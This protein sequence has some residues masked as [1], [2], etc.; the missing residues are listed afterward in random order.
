MYELALRFPDQ[1]P[2][3]AY[4]FEAG[5]LWHRLACETENIEQEIHAS[6]RQVCALM[7]EARG[8]NVEFEE[9]VDDWLIVKLS[10]KASKPG[11]VN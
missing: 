8:W 5:Q 11:A 10:Q 2:S 9:W 6:N 1:S 7:A 4:G 3:F